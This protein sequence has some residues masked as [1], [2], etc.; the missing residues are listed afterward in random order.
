M[1]VLELLDILNPD[2]VV[3]I[4]IAD[5]SKMLPLIFNEPVRKAEKSFKHKVV[6]YQEQEVSYVEALSS[7]KI[8]II[9]YLI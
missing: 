8:H 4:S 2:T 1:K 5:K 9:T 7:N 3:S 6:K